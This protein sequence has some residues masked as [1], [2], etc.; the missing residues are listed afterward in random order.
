MLTT[1][2]DENTATA[3]PSLPSIFIAK[4]NSLTILFDTISSGTVLQVGGSGHTLGDHIDGLVDCTNEE[5][6]RPFKG[7]VE[8]SC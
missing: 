7:T 1:R 6:W 3:V 8:I 4:R 5:N 2:L